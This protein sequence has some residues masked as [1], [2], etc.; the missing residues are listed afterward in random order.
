MTTLEQ[1]QATL[2]RSL[3]DYRDQV[4]AEL[5][6]TDRAIEAMT[7]A[8]VVEGAPE[9]QRRAPKAAPK[10]AAR[11]VG[12][13]AK[14]RSPEL[15]PHEPAARLGRLSSRV[16]VQACD[17]ESER[18]VVVAKLVKQGYERAE[19]NQRF[20]PGLYDVIR[21]DGSIVVTW[22]PQGGGPS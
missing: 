20:A 19:I 16:Q 4:A 22:W 1:A 10:K 14:K 7:G 6:A 15:A 11:A 9:K 12:R 3:Q 2:R 5:A 8:P 21:R 13:K 18:K 17:D